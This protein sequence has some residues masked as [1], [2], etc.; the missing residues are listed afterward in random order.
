MDP[1][2]GR[3][4]SIGL[5]HSTWKQ[6]LNGNANPKLNASREKEPIA[7]KGKFRNDKFIR[8][9]PAAPAVGR[10]LAVHMATSNVA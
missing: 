9:F 6:C 3:D 5:W 10:R 4:I 8:N 2:P 7:R 1:V